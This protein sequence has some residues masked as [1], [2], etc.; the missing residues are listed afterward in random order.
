MGMVRHLIKTNYFQREKVNDF[1]GAVNLTLEINPRNDLIKALYRYQK[2]D[3]E[4]AKALAEQV[5]TLKFITFL[6]I[7]IFLIFNFI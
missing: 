5:S 4:L 6:C 2:K 1:Y 7:L 3:P